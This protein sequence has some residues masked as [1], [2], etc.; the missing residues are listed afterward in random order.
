MWLCKSTRIH[1]KGHI[2]QNCMC[3]GKARVG[4]MGEVASY[5]NLRECCPLMGLF[6]LPLDDGDT[7]SRELLN[8]IKRVS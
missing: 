7:F 1:L 5:L 8:F 6:V 4:T 3:E 2:L